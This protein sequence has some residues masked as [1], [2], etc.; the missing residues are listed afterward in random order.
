MPIAPSTACSW[1]LAGGLWAQGTPNCLLLRPAELVD[2]G[3]AETMLAASVP[4]RHGAIVQLLEMATM[5]DGRPIDI[6]VLK[7]RCGD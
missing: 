5:P 7:Y 1:R 3:S 4:D 6:T 2:V